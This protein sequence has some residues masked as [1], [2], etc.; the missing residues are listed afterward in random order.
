VVL[1]GGLGIY[2]G[3]RAAEAIDPAWP[4]V[5]RVNQQPIRAD[6]ARFFLPDN[7]R[8]KPLTK[9]RED[10]WLA[11]VQS[12][13]D[14]RLVMSAL[15]RQK[16]A[17]SNQDIQFELDQLNKQLDRRESSLEEYLAARQISL[18]SYRQVMGWQLTWR[19]YLKDAMIDRNLARYFQKHHRDF[20]GTQLRVAHIF[21][22]MPPLDSLAERHEQLAVGQRVY[23]E[24]LQ[25][26]ISFADAVAKYS[27]APTG[28]A[29]GDIGWIS[30]HEPMSPAFN[31]AA[32]ELHLNEVSPPIATSLGMHLIRCQEIKP[33]KKKW[34]DVRPELST[35]V[36]RYLFQ[37]LADRERAKAEIELLEEK[38]K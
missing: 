33:G 32:F 24:I 27:E 28:T 26:K 37:W 5:A 1:V 17:A 18:A 31:K 2:R 4:I 35:A 14:R 25:A 38:R 8:Q 16:R 15:A 30:R 29:G 21:W 12:A 34:R 7:V 20:D 11:A 36:R 10:V 9:L 22:K 19:R 3:T 23:D 6:E 13:I